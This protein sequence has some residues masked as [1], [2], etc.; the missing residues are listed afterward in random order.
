MCDWLQWG[1]HPKLSTFISFNDIQP[2]R[3]AMSFIEEPNHR[4]YKVNVAF[5][6][7]DAENLGELVND[8]FHTDFGDNKFP[9]FKGNTH[10]GIDTKRYKKVNSND[11]SGGDSTSDD[12]SSSDEV[13]IDPTVLNPEDIERISKFIPQSMIG[14]LSTI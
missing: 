3:Y 13:E 5:I 6:A 10:V 12:D 4:A 8:N 2:S 7:L 9:Y 11:D 1:P 14:F